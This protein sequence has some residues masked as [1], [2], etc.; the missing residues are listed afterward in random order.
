MMQNQ[1]FKSVNSQDQINTSLFAKSH[2]AHVNIFRFDEL[3]ENIKLLGEVI[4]F[5]KKEDVKWI[6]LKL[7]PS[8]TV[9]K[10]AVWYQNKKTGDINC[11]IEDFEKIY[12]ANLDRLVTPDI[13]HVSYSKVD[14]D[15]WVHHVDKRKVKTQKLSRVRSEISAIA[16]DWTQLN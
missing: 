11:H 10:N 7:D 3:S 14:K 8:F 15:G 13:I 5:L 16:T 4:E 9:P 1:E 12:L 2:R 6:V